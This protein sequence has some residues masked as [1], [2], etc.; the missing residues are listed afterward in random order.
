LNGRTDVPIASLFGGGLTSSVRASM[1]Y[2]SRN[3]RMFPT[4][5]WFA[6]GSAEWATAYLGSDNLFTRFRGNIRRYFPLPLDGVLRLNLV[7][8]IIQAPEGRT[9]RCLSGSSWAA[10]SMSADSIAI[11]SGDHRHSGQR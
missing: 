11:H 6:T 3:D 4:T 5:G 2:D 7:G 9:V 8:G 1:T 10:S